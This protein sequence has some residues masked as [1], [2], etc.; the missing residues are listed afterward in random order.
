MG[1]TQTAQTHAVF[2]QTSRLQDVLFESQPL[3]PMLSH[4]HIFQHGEDFWILLKSMDGTHPLKKTTACTSCTPPKLNTEPENSG[5]QMDFP[6]P[7][8]YFQVPC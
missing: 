4:S 3:L 2:D 5:F 6:F 7:G 1:T 8:T